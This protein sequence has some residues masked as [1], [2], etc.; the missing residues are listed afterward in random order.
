MLASTHCTFKSGIGGCSRYVFPV[1]ITGAHNERMDRVPEAGY[2]V[3]L[4]IC[5]IH[6]QS[7]LKEVVE[8]DMT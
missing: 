8:D 2:K 5:N 6:A 7:N 3:G 1:K 4:E